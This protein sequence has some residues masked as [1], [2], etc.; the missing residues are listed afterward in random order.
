MYE[1]KD[2]RMNRLIEIEDERMDGGMK[3]RMNGWMEG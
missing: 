1:W 3:G 2:R